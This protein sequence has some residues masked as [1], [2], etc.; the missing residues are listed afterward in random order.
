MKGVHCSNDIDLLSRS[1]K[2][3]C[4]YIYIY[5]LLLMCKALYCMDDG[6]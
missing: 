5:I 3:V 4:V 2:G 6:R 1:A